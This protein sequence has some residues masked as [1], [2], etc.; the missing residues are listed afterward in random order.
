MI[1]GGGGKSTQV[2]DYCDYV[3]RDNPCSYLD[4]FSGTGYRMIAY[5]KIGIFFPGELWESTYMRWKPVTWRFQNCNQKLTTVCARREIGVRVCFFSGAGSKPGQ[6]RGF[7]AKI[8]VLF[9][10]GIETRNSYASSALLIIIINHY[11]IHILKTW[12]IR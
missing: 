10:R 1:G 3:T 8:V 9:P 5:R 6:K 4:K 11:L 7:L 2:P 12:C